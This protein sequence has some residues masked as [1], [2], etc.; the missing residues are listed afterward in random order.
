[1]CPSKHSLESVCDLCLLQL[2]TG[3]TANDEDVEASKAECYGE[4]LHGLKF[5]N[6]DLR[7][8]T[9]F[10]GSWVKIQDKANGSKKKDRSGSH[11]S[12]E[13]KGTMLWCVI[14]FA[15]SPF[16]ALIL[17]CSTCSTTIYY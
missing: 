2:V 11:G 14:L 10:H 15:I 8:D 17:Y 4:L 9:Q 7:S 3:A 13:K 16:F 12:A 1:M 6:V 5:T